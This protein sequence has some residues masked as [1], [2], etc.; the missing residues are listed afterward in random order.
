M[1][2]NGT[3][4]HQSPEEIEEVL[5]DSRMDLKV[6]LTSSAA[7]RPANCVKIWFSGLR[8]T[9]A[10]VLRR[11]RWGMPMMTDS[12]PNSVDT[13]IIS[14]SAGIIISQPSK[15]KR[16]SDEYF[17]A[18]NASKPV[19][20]VKRAKIRRFSSGV[21]FSTPGVSKRLRIQLHCSKELMNMN[22]TPI[23]LQ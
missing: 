12:T 8:Q 20:R 15:P 23:L 7:S 17:L 13:S 6:R 9:L 1:C 21:K 19:A 3:W 14:F 18:K 11:P 5:I 2:P 22:S 4:H 10:K 16:F